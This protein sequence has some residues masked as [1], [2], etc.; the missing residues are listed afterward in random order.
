MHEMSLADGVLRVIEDSAKA[1]RFSR[2]KTVWLEIGA[3][4]GVEVEA[5][6]FCFDAVMK[7]TLADGARLEIVTPE[8]QGLCL[9]CGKTVT[10]QQRYDPC[11]LCA[12]YPVK[13]T[14]GMEMR[15][16]ELEVE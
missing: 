13:P 10:I 6:R 1:N 5:M 14:G 16:K 2:V 12:G 8:G 4:S 11:P 7:D 9:A 15:V 3:L